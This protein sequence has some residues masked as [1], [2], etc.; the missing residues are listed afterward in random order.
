M[1]NGYRALLETYYDYCWNIWEDTSKNLEEY[2]LYAAKNI[3]QLRKSQVD[4]KL[5]RDLWNT[6]KEHVIEANLLEDEDVNSEN[7]VENLDVEDKDNIDMSTTDSY[8]HVIIIACKHWK[9]QDTTDCL[10][11][12]ILSHL[13]HSLFVADDMSMTNHGICYDLNVLEPDSR[14]SYELS[15]RTGIF[16]ATTDL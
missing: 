3:L 2:E 16:T 13:Y 6:A 8:S 11:S 15:V 10:E 4:A 12:S 9:E 1:F 7:E 5:N 14:I